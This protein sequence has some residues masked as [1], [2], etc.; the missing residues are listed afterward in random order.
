MASE[1]D[2]ARFVNAGFDGFKFMGKFNRS[3][4]NDRNG[5]WKTSI[6]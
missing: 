3:N 2:R 1:F 4:R 6:S 5:E